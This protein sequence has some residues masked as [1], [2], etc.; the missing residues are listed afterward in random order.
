MA[1]DGVAV[2]VPVTD[3]EYEDGDDIEDADIRA[4]IN[5]NS[6]K[7]NPGSGN[8]LADDNNTGMTLNLTVDDDYNEDEDNV[9]PNTKRDQMDV[10]SPRHKKQQNWGTTAATNN[11]GLAGLVTQVPRNDPNQESNIGG[12][13][14]EALVT[15]VARNDNQPRD[16]DQTEQ[17]I[18]VASDTTG[19][20]ACFSCLWSCCSGP[21]AP[22]DMPMTAQNEYQVQTNGDVASSKQQMNKPDGPLLEQETQTGSD[23]KNEV[24]DTVSSTDYDQALLPPAKPPHTG[25]K[26][27]VLD[28]DETLVHSSF[29]PIPKPDFII[30]VEIDR[31]VHHVYVLKRPYVDEFLLRASKYY[32]IVIFTAS[33][34][35]YAD[36]LLDK[37]DIH[38]VISHRLF[39]ES[40][41]IHGTAYVKDMR[42]IGRKL[43]DSIIVDNSPPSYLFQPT[44]AVP[45]ASWFDDQNDTQLLDFCP[46]LETTMNKIDDVRKILD[47]NNKSFRWL[48]N[49]AHRPLSEYT[50]RNDQVNRQ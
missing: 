14:A 20:C 15:Q 36:P 43:K 25:K 12:G 35:K 47:A 30:P 23:N 26:C 29:K 37:L 32:E 44:N 49:Q 7:G 16:D 3:D 19:F 6:P 17:D 2:D 46:V 5:L 48:C 13:G 42:R 50:V 45:I 11:A 38:N 1:D 22:A 9:T 18:R 28:L 27:L 34:S 41:V 10:N 21:Q 40:C 4:R 39:R 33:L 8:Y 31:V 24:E